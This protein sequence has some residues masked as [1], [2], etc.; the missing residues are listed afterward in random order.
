MSIAGGKRGDGVEA[1]SWRQNDFASMAQQCT[2]WGTL[3]GL[4][5]GLPIQGTTALERSC[6]LYDLATGLRCIEK[7]LVTAHSGGASRYAGRSCPIG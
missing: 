7:A 5:G 2:C 4:A 3:L 6:V 1:K